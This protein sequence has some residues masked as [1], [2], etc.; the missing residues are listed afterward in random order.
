MNGFFEGKSADNRIIQSCVDFFIGRINLAL[1]MAFL[2]FCAVMALGA[3]LGEGQVLAA[4]VDA[5]D[6]RIA[7]VEPSRIEPIDFIDGREKHGNRICPLRKHPPGM[8]VGM[9][10][11]FL[12]Y[13]KDV[14][15]QCIG[16]KSRV[17]TA[18]G[19][20]H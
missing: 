13:L 8:L 1:A 5:T 7:R 19:P 18:E 17:F 4:G 20:G 16:E 10:F 2:A 15:T 9:I 11:Q 3:W 12:A 14:V 6:Y